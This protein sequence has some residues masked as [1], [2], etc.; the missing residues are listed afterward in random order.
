MRVLTVGWFIS[1]VL[2]GGGSPGD[3]SQKP[4]T[5]I[6]VE[7]SST[8]VCVGL[9]CP[10]WPVP[11]DLGFCFQAEGNYY[12]GMYYSRLWPRATKGKKLSL[13][14]GQSLEIL[15]TDKE[16]RVVD[17]R[18]KVKLTRVH[19]SPGFQSDSCGHN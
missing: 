19:S 3:K 12:T 1:L 10:P 11:D 2:I 16:I 6:L 5:A 15:V 14:K 18:I 13:L 8:P 17:S 7:T 4:I 9:D